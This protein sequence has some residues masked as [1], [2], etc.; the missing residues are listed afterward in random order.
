M[1][2]VIDSLISFVEL[3]VEASLTAVYF[4]GFLW[5]VSGITGFLFCLCFGA[6]SVVLIRKAFHYREESLAW[7]GVF[8]GIISAMCFGVFAA[9]LLSP[10]T[11]MALTSPEAYLAAK[12]IGLGGG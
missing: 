8:A 11:W 1:D 9:H 7:T 3:A 5:M 10:L 12:F 4:Y 2:R 6:V